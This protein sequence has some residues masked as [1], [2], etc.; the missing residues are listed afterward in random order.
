[1]YRQQLRRT[2]SNFVAE[3]GG[4]LAGSRRVYFKSGA[5]ATAAG[6][7]RHATGDFRALV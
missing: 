5:T 1:L 2:G 7:A 4:P 6:A 3:S